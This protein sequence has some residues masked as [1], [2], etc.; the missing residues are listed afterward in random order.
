MKKIL[1]SLIV[2]VFTILTVIIVVVVVKNRKTELSIDS[3]DNQF[4]LELGKYRVYDYKKDK[5]NNCNEY[6]TFTIKSENDF[7]NKIIKSSDYYD[8]KL[9]FDVTDYFSFGFLTN[10]G[11]TFQ[12]TV[13]DKSVKII[14]TST[15]YIDDSKVVSY[16]E[17]S[18]LY[19]NYI[20]LPL[21]TPLYASRLD[22]NNKYY[23][24][25]GIDSLDEFQ[26]NYYT[27]LSDEN[28]T[29]EMILKIVDKMDKNLYTIA[30]NT[31]FVKGK[32]Y[33]YKDDEDI[34]HISDNYLVTLTEVDG[35]VVVSAYGN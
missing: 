20:Y 25:D 15:K 31:I 27:S 12:Y 8:E 21:A 7:Y 18:S 4:Q 34:L 33:D 29:F 22:I 11:Y 9:E 10:N 23:Q 6:I 19:E 30:D 24:E 3:F 32:Y 14:E 5:V 26:F 35:K 17:Y 1:T 16:D 28:I 2:I 13:K